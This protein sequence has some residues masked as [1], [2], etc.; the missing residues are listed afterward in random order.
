MLN[1]NLSCTFIVVFDDSAWSM[2]ENCGNE[3]V[4]MQNYILLILEV[5]KIT[6]GTN[7]EEYFIN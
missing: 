2:L 6:G 3:M 1:S 5:L 7:Y 4:C